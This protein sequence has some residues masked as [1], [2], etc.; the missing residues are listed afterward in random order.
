MKKRHSVDFD[1]DVAAGDVV[2]G[3]ITLDGVEYTVIASPTT[4]VERVRRINEQS[5][6]G[7]KI[8]MGDPTISLGPRG[9]C[10]YCGR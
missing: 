6:P 2:Q 5:G 3:T 8:G 7:R 4:E 1:A 10:P 9:G